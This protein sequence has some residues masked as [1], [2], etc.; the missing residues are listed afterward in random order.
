V[1]PLTSAR[2]IQS[3]AE[4]GQLHVGFETGFTG[5]MWVYRVPR[6]A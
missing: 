6:T 3:G 1:G 2:F 4:A 5:T